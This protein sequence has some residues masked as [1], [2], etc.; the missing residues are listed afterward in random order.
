MCQFREERASFSMCGEEGGLISANLRRSG[1]VLKC[2]ERKAS[3]GT[4]S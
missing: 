3:R 2:L 4:L 1:P